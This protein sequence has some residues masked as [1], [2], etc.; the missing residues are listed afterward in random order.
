MVLPVEVVLGRDPVDTSSAIYSPSR[1]ILYGVRQRAISGSA[2]GASAAMQNITINVNASGGALHWYIGLIY[3]YAYQG[4]CYHL[5]EPTLLAL[6]G[7]G[8]PAVGFNFEQMRMDPK[9][10]T[11][12]NATPYVMWPVEKLDRTVQLEMTSDTFEEML[13]KRTLQGAKQPM[14]Y[15]SRVSVSHRG[16]KLSE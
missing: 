12:T 13:L 9:T 16:G 11:W 3:A 10:N 8:V 5:P 7:E 6:E 14:A 15:A 4:H 2:L 1:L